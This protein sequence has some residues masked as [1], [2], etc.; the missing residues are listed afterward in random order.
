LRRRSRPE[1][2]GFG[3][4]LIES[5]RAREFGAEARLVFAPEGVECCIR[6]PLTPK[7]AAAG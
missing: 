2:L 1:R 3:S 6:L 4:R 7:G 5:D